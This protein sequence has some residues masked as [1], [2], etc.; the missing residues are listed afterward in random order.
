MKKKESNNGIWRRKVVK[1]RYL[2]RKDQEPVKWSR[3]NKQEGKELE[4]R[5]REMEGWNYGRTVRDGSNGGKVII[6]RHS[7]DHEQIKKSGE[8]KLREKNWREDRKRW[9]DG[10]MV[11]L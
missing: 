10:I 8:N 7:E 6:L 3:E 4:G 9:R 1:I 2:V 5:Q 11:E